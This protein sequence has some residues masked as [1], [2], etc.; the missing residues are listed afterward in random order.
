MNNLGHTDFANSILQ[1]INVVPAFRQHMLLTDRFAD[2]ML[3]KMA[4]FYK[5]VWNNKNFK[6]V[7]SPHELLQAI[8][9]KSN[10]LFK[11]GKLSDPSLFLVWLINNTDKLLQ[12]EKHHKF[13]LLRLFEGQIKTSFIRG[14]KDSAEYERIPEK[15]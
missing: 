5:K 3:E 10:K 7:I 6:G 11:I 13:N 14:I 1:M 15:V 12:K 2:D 9:D 8:S 4:L